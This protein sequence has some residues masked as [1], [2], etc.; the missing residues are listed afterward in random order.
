MKNMLYVWRWWNDQWVV[1]EE[2]P[3]V[4]ETMKVERAVKL[5]Q[6]RPIYKSTSTKTIAEMIKFS[7]LSPYKPGS[8]PKS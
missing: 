6:N 5:S 7:N 2:I 8:Q 3:E 4:E 1:H